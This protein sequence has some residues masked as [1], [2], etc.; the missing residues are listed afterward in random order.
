MKRP[1]PKF[2][3]K[4]AYKP[5]EDPAFWHCRSCNKIFEQ[6]EEGPYCWACRTYYEDVRNGLFDR[7]DEWM[8]ND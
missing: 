8:F 3:K 1:A 4:S 6:N 2:D 7:D 5:E